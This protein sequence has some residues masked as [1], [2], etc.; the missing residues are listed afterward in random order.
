MK[1]GELEVGKEY[2]YSRSTKWEEYLNE[3]S[4]VVVVDT[5]FWSQD[6]GTWSRTK[7]E[8]IRVSRGFGVLVDMTVKSY[9]GGEKVVRQ[10]VN[11]TTIRGPYEETKKK[12]EEIS[13]SRNKQYREAREASDQREAE[14]QEVINLAKEYGIKVYSNGYGKTTVSISVADLN[15][16]INAGR[17]NLG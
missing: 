9:S 5:G 13:E 6:R 1:R 2:W 3:G 15:R 7:P 8:P 17:Q 16:L 12:I 14:V 11:V 4:K 10:V